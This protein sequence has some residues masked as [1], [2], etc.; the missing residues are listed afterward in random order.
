MR[1]GRLG[2]LGVAMLVAAC[3]EKEF[4]IG[5]TISGLSGGITLQLNGQETLARDAD[6]PFT[7]ETRVK[8]E[9]TYAVT[10][11]SAPAEQDCTVEGG[12]GKVAGADVSSVQVRC[13]TK[14]YTLGGTV[15]GPDGTLELGL[16]SETLRVTTNGRFTFT[17]KQPKGS[18]YSVAVRTQ[19]SNQRC[20]VSDGSGTVTG[21]VEG[22]S[23]RCVYWYALDTFQA[24]NRVLGQADFTSKAPDRGGATGANTLRNLLGNPALA[25]GRLYVPDSGSNR[26]LGF[27]GVP[28]TDGA[29]AGFVLGQADF[30]D[31]ET[32]TGQSGLGNPEGL[33]S[34]GTWLAVADTR[35]SRVLLHTSLPAST[36]ATPARVLGQPG[37][38]TTAFGCART[39]LAFPED[40]FIGR[41]K[42]LVADSGNNRVLVWNTLPTTNG[43]P[44]DLVLGQRDFTS[45]TEND[46]DDNDTRDSTPGAT[47]LWNPTGVWT[48]G[49]R[50]VVAD[51]YNN[52][53]LIWNSFPTT[54]GQPA[55]VVLGQP[56]FASRAPAL[57]S[58]GMNTPYTVASTGLQLFVADS[59]NHRVLIWNALPTTHATPADAVLGQRDF[60]HAETRDPPTG[61][62]PSAHSLNQPGGVL[63]AW[64]HVVVSDYGNNRLLVFGSH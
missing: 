13:G 44:P 6:G 42:L 29:S 12:T 45:C 49:T 24:A 14:T 18:T 19:P 10:V 37:F 59:Q 25:G 8:D 9:G 31:S 33:S 61:T 11:T 3:G 17:T 40:V 2:L 26:V 20:S 56:D 55:D 36:G 7:F 30:A 32:G 52:R 47:T 28:A 38:D 51:S 21:N 50:L 23:V 58:T 53:V 34:D 64:P 43:A 15:E 39:S 35:N 5:G 57:T 46:A 27:N 16:G 60:T 1:I 54:H 4:R 41:G 63:L 48:D 62:T 22:I